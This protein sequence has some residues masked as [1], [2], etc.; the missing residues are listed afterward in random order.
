MAM[1]VER[2]RAY[3][4]RIALPGSV[5]V[6]LKVRSTGE[7]GIRTRAVYIDASD[8]IDFALSSGKIVGPIVG[9]GTT[10]TVIVQPIVLRAAPGASPSR[11]TIRVSVF[12]VDDQSRELEG[13]R[14]WYT[15]GIRIKTHSD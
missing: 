7:E 6:T 4:Q 2:P 15:V 12:E 13:T 9:A 3:P 8:Q 1:I 11:G 5:E 14:K 10:W